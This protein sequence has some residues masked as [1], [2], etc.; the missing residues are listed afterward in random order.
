MHQL[1][2]EGETVWSAGRSTSPLLTIHLLTLLQDSQSDRRPQVRRQNHSGQMTSRAG[3]GQQRRSTSPSTWHCPPV[4]P[5]DQQQRAS[6]RAQALLLHDQLWDIF[7]SIF[8]SRFALWLGD[9][10]CPYLDMAS[11]SPNQCCINRITCFY[12]GFSKSKMLRDMYR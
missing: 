6:R 9:S 12:S 3:G 11:V 4:S 7:I 5:S 2:A 8:E 10:C 1:Y